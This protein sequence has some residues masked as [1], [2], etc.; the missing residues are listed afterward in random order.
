MS[1]TS[2]CHRP[3]PSH[4]AISGTSIGL[5]QALVMDMALVVFFL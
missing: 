5:W 3:M 1:I 2:A 4:H